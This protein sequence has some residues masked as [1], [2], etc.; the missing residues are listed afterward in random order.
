MQWLFP[1]LSL[2]CTCC[3]IFYFYLSFNPPS[4]FLFSFKFLFPVNNYLPLLRHFYFLRTV[5]EWVYFLVFLSYSIDLCYW[6]LVFEGNIENLSTISLHD[7]KGG[8]QQYDLPLLMLTLAKIL[9]VRFLYCSINSSPLSI[10]TLWK[11]ISELLPLKEWRVM[12]PL[13]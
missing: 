8:N 11:E 6:L 1:I 3:H 5:L 12:L 9:F 2:L 4:I 10:L 7:I 13:F